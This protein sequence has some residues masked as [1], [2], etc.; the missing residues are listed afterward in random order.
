MDKYIFSLLPSTMN[1]RINNNNNTMILH[2]Y[3]G[4]PQTC[5]SLILESL[6]LN[7]ICINIY[8]NTNYVFNNA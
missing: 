7:I 2:Y 4:L 5:E 1:D 3:C 6:S 8:M